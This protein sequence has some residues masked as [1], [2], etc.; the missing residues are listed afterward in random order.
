MKNNLL[1][2]LLE[3]RGESLND[4]PSYSNLGQLI[5]RAG[6]RGG[7]E[8][9]RIKALPKRDWETDPRLEE[10]IDALTDWLLVR[11]TPCEGG[12]WERGVCSVCFSPRRLRRHQAKAL[13]ELHDYGRLLADFPVG[14]GKTLVSF[15]AP[16]VLAHSLDTTPEH[17]RPLLL[18]PA[19]L[20]GKTIKEFRLLA[21]HWGGYRKTERL[22][23]EKLSRKKQVDFL[24]R[25]E[26]LLIMADEAYALK[27]P[28][29]ARAKRIRRYRKARPE[30]AFLPL[31]GTF[32]KDTIHDYAHLS[33][34]ALRDLSPVPH[35]EGDAYVELMDWGNA[36]DVDPKEARLAAGMLAEFCPSP[37]Q[38]IDELR[39][40]LAIRR[41]QTPGWVRVSS[42]GVDAS[43]TLQG[44]KFDDYAAHVEGKFKA[45]RE[46]YETPDGIAFT[47]PSKLW[48]YL[49]CC[50]SGFWYRYDPL[51]PEHWKDARRTW[52]AFV[53]DILK[54]NKQRWDTGEQ[55]ALACYQGKLDS[56]GAFEEWSKVKSEYI[57]EDHKHTEWFDDSFIEWCVKWLESE[58]SL[59]F[60]SQIAVGER[61]KKL[62]GLPYF[63]TGGLDPDFGSIEDWRGGPAIAS[64]DSN[65]KGRNIQHLWHKACVVGGLASGPDAEQLIGRLHR[66]GTRAD[67]V[68]FTFPYGCLEVFETI[69]RAREQAKAA[70]NPMHKLIR[71]DFLV[72]NLLD[73]E[74]WK[75]Q[76]WQKSS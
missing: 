14:E 62:T 36:V 73:A 28:R 25:Y 1:G 67:V 22:S 8:F 13:Q 74:A 33:E 3:Q 17:L 43:L 6:V 7:A 65:K 26:P 45:L 55:V 19:N 42:S 49:K 20:E 12:S 39:A 5:R 10:L 18:L 46:S 57:P 37:P 58:K 31:T 30:V 66:P 32:F 40:A 76:R 44:L 61:L 16:V 29:G 52:G 63:H 48:N 35:H 9:E 53:R 70:D 60:T 41:N 69:H 54:Y 59:L 11:E 51:P 71:C 4:A 72:E 15:L 23:Y 38:S 34:W 47:E 64:V 21:N 75:G 24:D 68:E 2:Q 27:N 50:S 56:Y